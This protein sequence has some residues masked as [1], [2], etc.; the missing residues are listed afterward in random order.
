MRTDDI[1]ELAEVLDR[2]G[3][4]AMEVWGGATFD[5][6]LRFLL[7]DPWERLVKVRESVKKTKLMMLLRGSNLVGYRRYPNDVIKAFI[8][9]AYRDGIDIFRVFDALND[10][11]NLDYPIKIIKDVGAELQVCIAYTTSPI[12]TT[13]YYERLASEII[14]RFEPEW[15][16]IKDMA[17]LMDPYTGYELVKTLKGYGVKIDFHSHTTSGLAPMT[18]LKAVEAG[19]DAID[20]VISP[21][22]YFTS[23]TAAEPLIHALRKGGYEVKINEMELYRAAELGYEIKK[24]YSEFDYSLKHSVVDIKVLKHQIPGGMLSNLVTQLKQF[25]MEDKL[26]EVLEEVY[27]V[28]EDLG[29]PP[30][31]TP[32][33]QIV[34]AQAVLNVLSGRYA[35]IVRELKDYVLGKYGKPPGKIKEEIVNKVKGISESTEEA[36]EVVDL[37]VAKSRL[38]KQYVRKFEDYI[39][40]ALFPNEALKLL[41]IEYYKRLSKSVSA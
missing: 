38:P 26:E 16:T 9:Y 32:M 18:L 36:E 20:T 12:H 40:Y 15:I 33:S 31:V 17:G 10:L 11:D 3:Y 37:K 19:A 24:R 39:T 4:Y 30:L 13:E 34:G 27:K 41:E 1:I 35:T 29:W 5:A 14:S 23:H 21:L 7:E 8:E 2:V 28:R 22:A 25:K 6:P